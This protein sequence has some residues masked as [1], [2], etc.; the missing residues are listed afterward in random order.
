M[1]VE[2]KQF[3]GHTQLK[4]RWLVINLNSGP[5]YPDAPCGS[6]PTT[7]GQFFDSNYFDYHDGMSRRRSTGGQPW[8]DG[9]PLSPPRFELNS[10]SGETVTSRSCE[11]F[12]DG[13][14]DARRALDE[15]ELIHLRLLAE[16]SD[17]DDDIDEQRFFYHRQ[18]PK[19][20]TP[21]RFVE[22]ESDEDVIRRCK[23]VM[24]FS[25]PY[26]FDNKSQFRLEKRRSR[27]SCYLAQPHGERNFR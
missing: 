16:M 19:V 9:N 2:K 25:T 22:S 23:S 15:I 6:L 27:S 26:L 7:F 8:L 17:I 18:K 20:E 12:V 14:A 5:R 10:F 1:I 3:R 4:R 13:D 21:R 24:Q 11:D